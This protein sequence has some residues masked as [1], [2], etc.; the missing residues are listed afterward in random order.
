MRLYAYICPKCGAHL[1]PG[2]K[3]DCSDRDDAM[4]GAGEAND[5][6]AIFAVEDDGQLKLA[7]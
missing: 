5:W 2:E 4:T 6:S 7:V 1:D 3:C